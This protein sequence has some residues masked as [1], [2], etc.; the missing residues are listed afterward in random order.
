MLIRKI[1]NTTNEYFI[2]LENIACLNGLL[3][4][5]FIHQLYLT[6]LL[7]TVTANN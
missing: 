2:I 5:S 4:R 1:N 6:N 3:N 7:F